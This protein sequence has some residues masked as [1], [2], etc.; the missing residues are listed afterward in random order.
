MLSPLRLLLL[1]AL[2]YWF[3]QRRGWQVWR[4]M[5]VTAAVLLVVLT[6][7]LGANV[8]TGVQEARSPLAAACGGPPPQAIVVL[9]AGL[10]ARPHGEDDYAALD[11]ASLQRLLG[12]VALQR[13]L[14]GVPLLIA[15]GNRHGIATSAILASL[16][17][18]LG[19]APAMLRVETQSLDTWQNAH[20]S[21][22][23]QPALPRRIWLVTSRLHMA[24]AMFAFR[25]AGFEACAYPV[26]PRYQAFDGLGYLLP[27]GTATLKSEQALHE[28]VGEVAYRIRALFPSRGG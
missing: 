26:Q 17:R 1:V 11:L 7:P 16:A 21:A 25:Q 3:A 20:F 23:L 24:R 13:S 10:V 18:E 15:G 28:M 4:R 14:G 22:A 6:T 27:G 5:C 2:G 12:A 9:S 19:V 8:L